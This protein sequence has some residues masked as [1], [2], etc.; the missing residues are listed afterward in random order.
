MGNEQIKDKTVDNDSPALLV[1][2]ND[3]KISETP[4]TNLEFKEFID[5]TNYITDAQKFGFSYVFFSLLN[6]EQRKKYSKVPNA[7]WWYVVTQATWD[8][9]E[10]IESNIDNRWDFPVVHV[11]RNDALEYCKWANKRL[12]TEAEWEY[13]ARGGLLNSIYPWGNDFL[14]SNNEMRCNIW[15]GEFKY[16]ETTNFET[17][18]GVI[19]VKSFEP[20]GYGLYQMVGNIWE[21]CL[22]PA[23]IDYKFFNEMSALKMK[24]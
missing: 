24:E 18:N 20:N 23:R 5:K 1:K 2:V 12:P 19:K 17:K 22:N 3:F 11:S 4:I 21:W 14:D 6:D 8:H 13:S 9:P 15:K 7:D 16:S 10:G